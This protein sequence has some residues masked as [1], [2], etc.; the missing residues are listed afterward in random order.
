MNNASSA[1]TGHILNK[2]LYRFRFKEPIDL[3]KIRGNYNSDELICRRTTAR[4]DVEDVITFAA[5]AMKEQYD[6]H[7]KTKYFKIENKVIL[8]LYR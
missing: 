2:I 5:M 6:S 7:H 4:K 8:C 3:L 1:T